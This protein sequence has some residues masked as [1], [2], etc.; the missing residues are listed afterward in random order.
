MRLVTRSGLALLLLVSGGCALE[1]GQVAQEVVVGPTLCDGSTIPNRFGSPKACCTDGI[2]QW[3]VVGVGGGS[4]PENSLAHRQVGGNACTSDGVAGS[5]AGTCKWGP[6]AA[7]NID[8]WPASPGMETSYVF[9]PVS[10]P[11]VCGR[12]PPGGAAGFPESYDVGQSS[13]PPVVATCPYTGCTGSVPVVKLT[14]NGATSGA[15]GTVKSNPEGIELRGA[16]TASL[17]T[18]DLDHQLRARPAGRRARAVFS[19][20]CTAVGEYGKEASCSLTLGPDKLVVV[21]YSCEPGF[22]CGS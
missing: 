11:T 7:T 12:Q 8:S 9:H 13:Y 10:D 6:C 5:C 4:Q 1:V 18:H 2:D 15:T 14:V 3:F 21:T 17:L 22:T 20:H 19:G 16:G